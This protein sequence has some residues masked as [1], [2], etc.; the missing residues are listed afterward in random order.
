MHIPSWAAAIK[1]QRLTAISTVRIALR[2]PLEQIGHIAKLNAVDLDRLNTRLAIPGRATLPRLTG[3]FGRSAATAAVE[4]S[5]SDV[6]KRNV[7]GQMAP[8]RP[9]RVSH[10]IK[11]PI[12]D[13]IFV[14]PEN[15][16][17]TR[18]RRPGQLVKEHGPAAGTFCKIA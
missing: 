15:E 10:L 6:P 7:F 12:G 3:I 16:F 9:D 11:S 1:H 8:N 17:S 18:T 13:L 2:S 4:K 14:S 5:H